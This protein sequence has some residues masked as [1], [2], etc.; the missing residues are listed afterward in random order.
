MMAKDEDVEADPFKSG[1][2]I[3]VFAL[4]EGVVGGDSG[5]VRL[6]PAKLRTTCRWNPAS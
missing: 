2:S 4:T 5:T 1:E 6:S 3:T